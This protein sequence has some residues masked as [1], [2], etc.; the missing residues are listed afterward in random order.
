ML[1]RKRTIEVEMG[2]VPSYNMTIAP[3]F[4]GTQVDI[5]RP[6]KAYFPHIKRT[7]LKIWLVVIY[8]MTVSTTLVKVMEDC[9]KITFVLAFT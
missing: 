8:C 4:Y 3:V 9:S 5:C 1:L 2:P 6:L 7:T